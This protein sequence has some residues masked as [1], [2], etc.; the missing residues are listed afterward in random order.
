MS[1]DLIYSTPY[2]PSSSF[3][4]ITLSL[5]FNTAGY[6]EL[7]G[8]GLKNQHV[9]RLLQHFSHYHSYSL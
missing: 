6:V 3:S 5:Y 4:S 1:I 8:D 2:S 9:F 7:L